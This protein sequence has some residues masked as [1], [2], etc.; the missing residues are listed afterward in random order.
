MVRRR[1]L[2]VKTNSN[3]KLLVGMA[4]NLL[5]VLLFCHSNESES[6]SYVSA[7]T[8]LF[9]EVLYFVVS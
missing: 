6:L 4:G 5:C 8:N 3:V 2:E 9:V 1:T 7:V